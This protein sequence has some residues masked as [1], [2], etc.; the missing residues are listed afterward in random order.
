H[1]FYFHKNTYKAQTKKGITFFCSY[2][3]L[4]CVSKKKGGGV[5]KLKD[6]FVPDS[7]LFNQWME[8]Y[9][10]SEFWGVLPY[11]FY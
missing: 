7:Y 10:G 6:Y 4:F 3:I 11:F 5:K 9:S 8:V 1:E 2:P